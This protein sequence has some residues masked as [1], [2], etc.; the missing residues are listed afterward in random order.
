[1]KKP[2]ALWNVMFNAVTDVVA[3]GSP[4]VALSLLTWHGQRSTMFV[5]KNDFNFVASV[6]YELVGE[7]YKRAQVNANIA[8]MIAEENDP[9]LLVE[10]VTQLQQAVEKATKGFMIATG[11]PLSEVEELEHN[12][13]EAFLALIV[14]IMDSKQE[15]LDFKSL[16]LYDA[17]TSGYKLIESMFPTRSKAYRKAKL[18]RAWESLFADVDHRAYRMNTDWRWWRKEISTW[19]EETINMM[20]DGHDEYRSRWDSY[21]EGM[22]KSSRP[23]KVDPRP[24]LSGDV[25]PDTWVFDREYAGLREWYIEGTTKSPLR[26]QH[27]KAIKAYCDHLIKM[28]ADPVPRE[29]WP[30]SVDLQVVLY[31]IRDYTSALLFLYVAGV[32]TTP[33]ATTSRYPSDGSSERMG[34]QNYTSDLGIIRCVGRLSH[35]TEATIRRLRKVMDRD[36]WH[37]LI[38]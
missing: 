38:E 22:N 19:S 28:I 5:T 31:T 35:E 6:D 32:I 4:S 9:D 8:K 10:A 17:P 30:K 26:V 18:R 14:R 24:L 2:T 25:S 37:L 7:W 20:L 34:T 36:I 27:A 21:I 11:A 13:S 23:K 16:E 29:M 12:T 1:M 15:N 33:H 3:C